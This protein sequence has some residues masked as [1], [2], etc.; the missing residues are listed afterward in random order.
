MSRKTDPRRGG[1]LRLVAVGLTI[2]AV[3]RELRRPPEQRTWQGRVAGVPY[4]FRPPTLERLKRSFWNP[5]D[6]RVF[7]E[8]VF[9]VG[10][11][12]NLGRLARQ[13]TER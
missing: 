11:A 6:P 5:A 1:L 4:D 8:P 12:V 3:A 9:G 7:T 10:W 2:A 13:L